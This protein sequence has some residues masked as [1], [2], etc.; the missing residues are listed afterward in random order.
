MWL[1]ACKKT[2]ATFA[3]SLP[4]KFWSRP[5]EQSL[6]FVALGGEAQVEL[7]GGARLITGRV[8][9][10]GLIEAFYPEI[11]GQ[12]VTRGSTWQSVCR[13]LT[14]ISTVPTSAH[15]TPCCSFFSY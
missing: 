3:R 14:L 13:L 8:L 6:H 9:K 10:L 5:S 11:V 7:K 12:M 15:C 2:F 1:L 4:P